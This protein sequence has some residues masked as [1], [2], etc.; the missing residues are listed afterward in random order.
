MKFQVVVNKNQLIVPIFLSNQE[1][2]YDSN[3]KS[4]F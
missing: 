3:F 2:N 1:D 4:N